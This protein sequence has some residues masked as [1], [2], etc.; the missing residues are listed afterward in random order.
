MSKF[1]VNWTPRWK[2]VNGRNQW[3][4]RQ[5]N[6]VAKVRHIKHGVYKIFCRIDNDLI[7]TKTATNRKMALNLARAWVKNEITK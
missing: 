2:T 6:R 5:E 7:D 1:R 3:D 4:Y